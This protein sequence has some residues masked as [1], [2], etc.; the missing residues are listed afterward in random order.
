MTP[1]YREMILGEDLVKIGELSGAF[2]APPSGEHLMFAYFESSLVVRYIVEK[3]GFDNL[4]KI[5]RDL[6]ERGS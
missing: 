4:L 5:L 6:M 3:F 2:L 1:R